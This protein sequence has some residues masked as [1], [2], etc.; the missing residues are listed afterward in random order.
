MGQNSLTGHIP[1]QLGRLSALQASFDLYS[2]A[3]SSSIPT[4]LG[5]MTSMIMDLTLA[6][7]SLTSA[8]PTELG[9]L[10]IR[11]YLYVSRLSCTSNSRVLPSITQLHPQLEK[12]RLTSKIPTQ[13]GRMTKLRAHLYL[14]SNSLSGIP[15]ELGRLT[16]AREEFYLDT[17]A[18][19]TVPT[20]LGQLTGIAVLDLEASGGCAEGGLLR[21]CVCVCVCVWGAL[22]G[23]WTLTRRSRPPLRSRPP[24]THQSNR[25]TGAAPTELG[26]LKS[27]KEFLSFASNELTVSV[28]GN[29]LG[30]GR[31]WSRE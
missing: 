21:V 8:V 29:G 7:N 3:L 24:P 11:Q 14:Y 18:H 19:V 28:G 9:N 10:D 1:T 5:M 16:G 13:L 23:T 15:T 31:R 30:S 6:V 17:N 20:E 2:N 27:I 4:E 22:S 12:N 25:L 26:E